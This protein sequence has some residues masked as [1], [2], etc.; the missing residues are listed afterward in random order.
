[1]LETYTQEILRKKRA[2][3]I[4]WFLVFGFAGFLYFFFQGYYPSIDISLKEIFSS[5]GLHRANRDEFIKSFGIVNV[6]VN[7][8]D[9]KIL[10]SGAD[11]VND[12]KR[13]VNYDTYTLSIGK[14]G[15]IQSRVRF[16]IDRE[17]PYYIDKVT[18]IPRAT[19]IQIDNPLISVSK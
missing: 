15:Y 14:P 16:A 4:F 8:R 9:A 17:T 7:P 18:L 11:F 6:T 13:M 10:L 1:M 2:S 12:E 5:G 19:Y 3:R